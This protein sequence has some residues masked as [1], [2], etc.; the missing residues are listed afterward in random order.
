[1]AK[2][3]KNNTKKNKSKKNKRSRRGGSQVS[4]AV[5]GLNNP[6]TNV[7]HRLINFPK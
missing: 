7:S 4:T 3:Y 1:M 2:S 6:I 5:T